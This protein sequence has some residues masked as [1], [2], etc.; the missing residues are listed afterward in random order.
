MLESRDAAEQARHLARV[1]V[2]DIAVY[3]QDKIIEGIR[4][5]TLFELLKED[6]DAGRKYYE[7]KVDPAVAERTEYFNH[8]LVDILVKGK[9]NIPSKI[10]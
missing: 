5:D 1:I 2:S 4:Q 6:I 8:A 10:W 7:E 3:N 9:G